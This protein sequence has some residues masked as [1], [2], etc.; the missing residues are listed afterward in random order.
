LGVDLI[1]S[2]GDGVSNVRIDLYQRARSDPAWLARKK[3]VIWCFS[4]REFTESTNGWRKLPVK[5]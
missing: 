1:A 5:K 3:V 4:A 2:R